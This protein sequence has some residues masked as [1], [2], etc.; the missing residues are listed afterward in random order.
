M[1]GRGPTKHQISYVRSRL[2]ALHNVTVRVFRSTVATLNETTGLIDYKED[3]GYSGYEGT[4]RL[5]TSTD[6]QY[7]N[8]AEG[9]YST[10]STYLSL[11][12]TASPVPVLDDYVEIAGYDEDPQ[13]EARLFRVVAIDGGGFMRASRRLTLVAVTRNRS[14]R[15]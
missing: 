10:V 15:P 13:M 7:I 14:D 11:P 3:T 8:V 6:G 9:D 2:E 5:W 4:G 1:A 12:F